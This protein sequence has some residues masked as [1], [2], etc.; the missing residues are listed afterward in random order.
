MSNLRCEGAKEMPTGA[1]QN[2]SLSEVHCNHIP[3]KIVHMD[4]KRTF[5]FK[6]KNEIF[7]FRRAT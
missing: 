7:K 3:K 5:A 6:F 4:L 1:K 2:K